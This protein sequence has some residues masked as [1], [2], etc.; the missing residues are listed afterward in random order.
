[1]EELDFMLQKNTN[2]QSELNMKKLMKKLSLKELVKIILDSEDQKYHFKSESTK[3]TV[4]YHILRELYGASKELL[5]IV[6]KENEKKNEQPSKKGSDGIEEEFTKITKKLEVIKQIME[7]SK[8]SHTKEFTDFTNNLI[9]E[10]DGIK[11]RLKYINQWAEGL[12]NFTDPTSAQVDQ[13]REEIPKILNCDN[14]EKYDEKW[15]KNFL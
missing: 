10:L 8:K 13:L 9:G 11:E 2:S 12:N 1:M 7:K 6:E 4:D 5:N 15:K 3:L 14:L